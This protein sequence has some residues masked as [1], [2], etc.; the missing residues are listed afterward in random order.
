MNQPARRILIV[1]DEP[2]LLKMMAAYLG[3][4][5][6]SVAAA[7]TTDEAWAQVEQAPGEFGVAVLDATMP[8]IGLH[9][10]AL[11]MVEASPGL[12]VLAASGYPVD[13]RALAAEAPGRI[14]FLQK[15]FT[16]KMLA[17]A[18]GRLLGP[19]KKDV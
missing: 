2:T 11:K 7:S 13:M 19:E 16:P 8:G 12:R 14:E 6:Y 3:R 17:E 18:V 4:L 5:G 15:P 1:D 10:L 9:D